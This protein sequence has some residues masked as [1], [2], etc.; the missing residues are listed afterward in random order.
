[1]E[2]GFEDDVALFLCERDLRCT[3]LH[4]FQFV[5]LRVEDKKI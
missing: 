2:V 3:H 5:D 1:M 4:A